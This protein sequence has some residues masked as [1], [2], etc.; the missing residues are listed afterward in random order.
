MTIT[1]A[2]VREIK[3]CEE[4]YVVS[5]SRLSGNGMKWDE[6]RKLSIL[7]RKDA[8][9]SFAGNTDIAFPLINQIEETIMVHNNSKNRFM[10]V[11]N[12]KGHI[13]NVVNSTVASIDFSGFPNNLV[14]E[15][16]TDTFE[17]IE[18]LFGGYSWINKKFMVWRIR[19]QKNVGKFV[20][21]SMYK[22]KPYGKIIFAGDMKSCAIKKYYE[23]GKIKMGFNFFKSEPHFD[24]EPLDVVVELL[25]K[26]KSDSGS[27][28]GGAPQIIKIYQ[29]MNARIIGV[30]WPIEDPVTTILGRKVL[31][32]ENTDVLVIDPVTKKFDTPYQK[33]S[34]DN[35]QK[36]N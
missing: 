7:P 36:E 14:N 28:I 30:L 32:Y 15:I 5:D 35:R 18:F 25:K 3:G 12:L 24:M 20:A 17:N 33:N 13:L 22:V 27:T 23:L 26:Y 34:V 31:S 29:H 16:R 9:I 4:L 10:D 21:D 1:I 2:W 11:T 19:Y 6:C 8:F